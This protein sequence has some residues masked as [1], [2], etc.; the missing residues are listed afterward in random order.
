MSPARTY[1]RYQTWLASQ[2]A[3]ASPELEVAATRLRCSLWAVANN[4]ERIPVLIAG[5]ADDVDAFEAAMQ[6]AA[7]S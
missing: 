3:F 4:R 7:T 1:R 2:Q 5:L 6:D